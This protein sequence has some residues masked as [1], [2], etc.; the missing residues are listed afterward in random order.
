M[1][2]NV[3]VI[4][5]AQIV[6]GSGDHTSDVYINDSSNDLV[7]GGLCYLSGGTI[8]PVTAGASYGTD[9]PFDAAKKYFYSLADVDVSEDA[10]G[11]VDVVEVTADTVF[12]GYVVDVSAT[13]DVSMAQT[14]I[15]TLYDAYIDANG[16][17][18]LDQNTDANSILVL[19]DVMD[20][21]DPWRIPDSEDPEEDSGGV[22]HDR[23][24]FS[25]LSSLFL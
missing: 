25:F 7:K 16:R 22:R 3:N 17:L 21:Y 2:A 14:D 4:A 13:G 9:A 15:G 10:A 18:A 24:R 23:V 5:G 12:E 6:S 1:A 8:V 20:N 11:Y 19:L